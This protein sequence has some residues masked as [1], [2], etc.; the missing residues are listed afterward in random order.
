MGQITSLLLVSGTEYYN[1]IIDG[2][3]QY[4]F[5]KSNNLIYQIIFENSLCSSR[6]RH[7]SSTLILSAGDL[8]GERKKLNKS[9][10]SVNSST[11]PWFVRASKN[12]ARLTGDSSSHNTL[13]SNKS[14]NNSDIPESLQKRMAM[15][16]R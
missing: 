10:P 2:D 16:D 7:L 1:F 8:N 3:T 11:C 4:K 5:Q 15:Q 12:T 6:L 14:N 9:T 13:L